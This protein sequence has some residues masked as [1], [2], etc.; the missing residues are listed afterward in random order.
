MAALE[1]LERFNPWW[2][3]GKVREE[4]LKEYRRSAYFEIAK[5]I[6]KRQIILIWGLRR[7]GKT[8]LM[9]Q[10][11]SELLKKTGSKNILYFSFDEISFDLKEVLEGYQK[12]ILGR[13]FEEM[14]ET[15]YVFLDE[16]QKVKDWENKLKIYYDL[17]PDVKFFTSGSASVGL[18]KKSRESLAGRVLDFLLR[19]LSFEEFLEMNGKEVKRIK[20]KPELWK[21][22]LL[23]LFYRYIKYGTFPELA[24]EDDEEFARKYIL[25]NI[26]ERIIY[27]DLPEEF[28]LK[29][30]ELLKSLVYL[31][32]KNPGM[33]VN[34]REIS[35]NLGKDQRTVANYFEYLEFGLLIRFVFNY[36]GSPIAS[37]RKLK[38]AYFNTPNIAFVFNLDMDRIFPKLL[39]NVVASETD[40]KFFYRDGFEIDFVIPEKDKLVAIEVKRT[41]KDAKQ[42]RKFIEKFESRV[43]KTMIVDMEKEGK[44]DDIE[45]IPAWKFILERRWVQETPA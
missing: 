24:R 23:P 20:E 38:K 40:A 15:V 36:R 31:L 26:I 34:Y 17:Y 22:D 45:I 37:L 12:F 30:V 3:T 7:V 9:L 13:T 8:T 1:D 39:E 25:N 5:Y 28:G 35:K 4:W 2:K 21:R 19:P 32:G 18:R 42:V 6:G 29:D 10:I 43:K 41:E 27:K 44:V 33:L 11:I 16:I 14:K